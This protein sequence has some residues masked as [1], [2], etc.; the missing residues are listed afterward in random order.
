MAR[1]HINPETGEPGSCR[2]E[3]TCPFGGSHHNSPELARLSFERSQVQ[4][5]FNQLRKKPSLSSAAKALDEKGWLI[6]KLKKV[7]QGAIVAASLSM[8]LSAC[9]SNANYDYEAPVDTSSIVKTQG[10]P[11]ELESDPTAPDITSQQFKDRVNQA[12]EEAKIQFG[13]VDPTPVNEKLNELANKVI[14]EFNRE[15]EKEY[16]SS[17][18]D[19]DGAT[20]GKYDRSAFKH[21]SDLDG[22][23]CDTR[24]DILHRDMTN[25]KLD[26][27]GC[28]VLSGTLKDPYTGKTIH[29]VRGNN[30]VDIDHVVSLNSA[31]A[32]G[33]D[34][35]SSTKRE[36]FANDSSNL[37]AVDSGAN[38]SKGPQTPATWMPISKANACGY[39][40]K[41]LEV[42]NSYKLAVSQSDINSVDLACQ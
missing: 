4:N 25:I 3:H 32:R 42:S 27:D 15:L 7:A 18:P 13:N 22:N 20:K 12:I 6:P 34:K 5:T 2:A 1:Y 40:V 9:N 31:W 29:Y 14:E 41:F 11:V 36:Q 37:L 26:S 8:V 33:A 16:G 23:N 24:Q 10:A 21:W 39:G 17:I 38:R 19:T 30:T 35:W 28:T